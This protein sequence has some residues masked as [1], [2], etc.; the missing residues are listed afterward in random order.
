MLDASELA[1]LRPT[2]VLIDGLRVVLTDQ[3][4]RVV[5]EVLIDC[6]RRALH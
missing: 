6:Q 2:E 1:P 3:G 4:L 5:L